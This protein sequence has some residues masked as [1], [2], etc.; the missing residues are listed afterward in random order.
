MQQG[1]KP[2]DGDENQAGTK[3][4]IS[5]PDSMAIELGHRVKARRK[6]DPAYS[7]NDWFRALILDHFRRHPG[8]GSAT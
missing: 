3:M 6:K 2:Q 7:R 4:T 5:V 1:T 8:N